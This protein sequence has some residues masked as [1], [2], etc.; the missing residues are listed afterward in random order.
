MK[1]L[2]AL[3]LLIVIVF[4]SIRGCFAQCKSTVFVNQSIIRHD[5]VFCGNPARVV[6][7]M[8]DCDTI[9]PYASIFVLYLDGKLW[10]KGYEGEK[11]ITGQFGKYQFEEHR[12][13]F[14]GKCTSEI[15]LRFS[16]INN[17][18]CNCK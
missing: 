8:I 13:S 18:Q 11:F 14:N 5:T 9:Q 6:S 17:K 2:I 15:L 16:I 4:L 7:V 12:T 10:Q 3:L 1:K